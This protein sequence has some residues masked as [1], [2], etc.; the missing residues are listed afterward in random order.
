MHHF[1]N[2]LFFAHTTLEVNWMQ[3]HKQHCG[4]H[5]TQRHKLFSLVVHHMD[6]CF[7]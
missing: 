2:A 6:K 7:K 3:I 1:L 4:F 5:I